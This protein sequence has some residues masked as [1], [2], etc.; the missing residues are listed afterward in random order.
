M[1]EIPRYDRSL[2]M[3]EDI[4]IKS[5]KSFKNVELHWHDYYELIVYYDA[6]VDCYLNGDEFKLVDN[7]A[8]LLTP[9]DFHKTV[10]R[11]DDESISFLNISFSENAFDNE[12]IR[13]IK[14]TRLVRC[15]SAED[16]IIKIAKLIDELSQTTKEYA[17][18]LARVLVGL[19]CERGECINGIDGSLKNNFVKKVSEYVAEN[20]MHTISLSSVSDYLHLA[21]AYFSSRFSKLTGY[22]FVRYL[23]IFRLN[24]AKELLIHSEKTITDICFESGFSNLSHFLR[25][26]KNHFGIAPAKYRNR[27]SN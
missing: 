3:G 20:F 19:I 26:F 14:N 27:Y 6:D 1:N 12:V 22:T 4:H 2:L 18:S 8:Y 9:Y 17:I 5:G 11:R 13:R 24:Y 15:T 16:P 21:P 10:N 23:T 25:V 7:A